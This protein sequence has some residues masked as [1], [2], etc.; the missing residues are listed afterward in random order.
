MVGHFQNS[1]MAPADATR[2][3]FWLAQRSRS[4]QLIDLLTGVR[5]TVIDQSTMFLKFKN[6]AVR[7]PR[8]INYFTQISVSKYFVQRSTTTLRLN[9]RKIC[10]FYERFITRKMCRMKV[11]LRRQRIF[12]HRPRP[13]GTWLVIFKCKSQ[14]MTP[15]KMARRPLSI[16]VQCFW[17]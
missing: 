15:K 4:Y 7:R 1:K 8:F 17:I 3:D 11:F 10:T 2:L 6:D 9:N 16:K 14:N 12:N 5:S 13:L